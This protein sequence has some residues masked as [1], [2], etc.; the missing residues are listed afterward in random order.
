MARLFVTKD[1]VLCRIRDGERK[2]PSGIIIPELPYNFNKKSDVG[3]RA[4]VLAVGP[5]QSELAPGDEVIV[6]KLGGVEIQ[7]GGEELVIFDSH[8]VLAKVESEAEAW[9][10][11]AIVN[12]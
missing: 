9:V 11:K 10:G 8:E 2:R 12:G 7:V 5:W 4:T 3:T 6:E 1:R